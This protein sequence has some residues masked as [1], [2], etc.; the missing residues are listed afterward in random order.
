[1]MSILF[2]LQIFTGTNNQEKVGL[3]WF[4]AER[5]CNKFDG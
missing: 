5:Y 1:M 2:V 3:S 4:G